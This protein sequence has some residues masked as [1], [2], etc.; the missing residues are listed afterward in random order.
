MS[1]V[2][3]IYQGGMVVADGAVAAQNFINKMALSTT[4]GTVIKLTNDSVNKSAWIVDGYLNAD[5]MSG[6]SKSIS[7]GGA[8]DIA[9]DTISAVIGMAATYGAGRLGEFSAVAVG[10][11]AEGLYKRIWDEAN[12]AG[13]W[14]G[15]NLYEKGWDGIAKDLSQDIANDEGGFLKMLKI[16]PD[17][18]ENKE[19]LPNP[20]PI[21]GVIFQQGQSRRYL[22]RLRPADPRSGR[23]WHRNPGQQPPG[24]RDVGP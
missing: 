23:R 5:T 21:T 4:D 20:S 22:P 3:I 18:W 9:R 2:L 14:W 17:F 19:W 10:W 12:K 13:Q 16:F 6:I 11:A 1:R 7:G 8:N 15:Q 24:R